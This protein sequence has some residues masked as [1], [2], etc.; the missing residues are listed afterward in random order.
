MNIM[1]IR[2][3]TKFP[4]NINM[5]DLRA[6]DRIGGKKKKPTTNKT[7]INRVLILTLKQMTVFQNFE[8]LITGVT[9]FI[10]R[11]HLGNAVGP[12]IS[13]LRNSHYK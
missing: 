3:V 2:M 6:Q 10:A 8:I 11:F 7:I 5:Y 12:N 13:Q 1:G 4:E 9:K